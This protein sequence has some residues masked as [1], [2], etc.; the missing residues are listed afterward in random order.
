[1]HLLKG[2][3]LAWRDPGDATYTVFISE[4][5]SKAIA[6]AFQ[7]RDFLHQKDVAFFFFFSVLERQLHTAR[8]RIECAASIPPI[9]DPGPKRAELECG[10][11][12]LPQKRR[13]QKR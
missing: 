9:D 4:K 6:L 7:P 8:R 3:P 1:M 2:S 5:K 11:V 13:P 12:Q 10:V